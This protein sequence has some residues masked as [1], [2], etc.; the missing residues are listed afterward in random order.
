MVKRSG[1]QN[2]PNRVSNH[3]PEEIIRGTQ[4]TKAIIAQEGDSL[5]SLARAVIF[6]FVEAEIAEAVG[7]E[8]GERP[9]A[10]K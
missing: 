9:S 3:D 4:D 10:T 8:K 6:E 7:A 2:R 1:S 5:R